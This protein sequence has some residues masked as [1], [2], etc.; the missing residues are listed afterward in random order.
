MRI[1][2]F[3]RIAPEYEDEE[4]SLEMQMIYIRW[5]F[6]DRM[7]SEK[8]V[9]VVPMTVGRIMVDNY[10]DYAKMLMDHFKNPRN[11][12]IISSDFCHWGVKYNYRHRFEMK[13]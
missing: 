12:F 2:T 1:A 4:H 9:K 7:N 6:R 13:H 8:D 11:L 10:Y 5:L 3:E